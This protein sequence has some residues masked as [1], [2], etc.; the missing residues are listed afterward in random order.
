[1]GNDAFQ[2]IRRQLR[3]ALVAIGII[4]PIAVIGFMTIE[5]LSFIDAIW[6]TVITLATIGYGDIYAQTEPGRIFT[7]L[8]IFSGL[9]TFA[10]A[11]QA[12]VTFLVSPAIRV[13]RQRRAAMNKIARLRG[14]YILCG[15]GP[16]VDN[17][18]DF[19]LDRVQ[20]RRENQTQARA[21]TMEINLQ[22]YL[23]RTAFANPLRQPLLKLGMQLQKLLPKGNTLID[24]LVVITESTSYAI[25]LREAG[26]L[27]I[28]AD[29]T[30]ESALQ[31][32]GI[33]HA[34][35]MMVMLESDT[36]AL[37][38]VLTARSQNNDIY[39]TAATLDEE[40]SQ[41]M[42]RVGANT[43]IA[44]YEIAAQFLTNATLRPVVNDFYND[45]LYEQ[46]S[47]HFL[48]QIAL[49]EDS[50]WIGRPLAQIGLRERF[51]ACIIA[52]RQDD[53]S[54]RATPEE[55]YVL[56]ENEVALVLCSGAYLPHVQQDARREEIWTQVALNWQRLPAP[57]YHPS[58]Q[59]QYSLLDAETAIQQMSEHFLIC[60]GGRLIRN[61][62]DKLDPERAFVIITKDQTLTA[63]L[64]RRGF[65]VL[66][67]DPTRE[68]VLRRAGIQRALAL[69]VSIEDDAD[70][71]VTVLNARTLSKRLLITAS[72]S[73]DAMGTKLQRAGADRVITPFRVAA[74]YLLL[75]TTRPAVSDFLHNV[76]YNYQTGFET[77]ELYMQEDS[78]WIGKRL[79]DLHLRRVFRAGVL[80]IRLPN[81]HFL[82]APPGT[83]IIRPNEVLITVNP[84][85]NSDELR[86]IAHGSTTKRPRTLRREEILQTGLWA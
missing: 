22:R 58:T 56:G 49:G 18:I 7:I 30:N 31:N 62:V 45:L 6:L 47:G 50:P 77:N 36:E 46:R 67:G 14:H 40:L 20:R 82:Y 3:I 75:A 41:K 39:I 51:N 4:L 38:V 5:N 69:M 76:L 85:V 28:E 57:P 74:R 17:T 79:D 44:P 15:S 42:I 35:A 72:A 65:R 60:G 11:A 21:A 23:G 37:L 61:V 16:L 73:S 13:G 53:G 68:D 10:Y 34:Q 9:G 59:R 1:M 26:F 84:I 48:V 83:H 66:H 52:V 43:V 64:L 86:A 19:L 54:Y 2:D 63:D 78:P 33:R 55:D 70:A 32:A 25:Q 71:L 8:L 12:A 29:P 81:G 80:G 24:I 27:V